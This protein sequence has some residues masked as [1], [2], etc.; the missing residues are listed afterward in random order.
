[1]NKMSTEIDWEAESIL[2][3][4]KDKLNDLK[5]KEDTGFDLIDEL[6]GQISMSIILFYC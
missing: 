6:Q 4:M 1:M 2:K 3:Y 5:A